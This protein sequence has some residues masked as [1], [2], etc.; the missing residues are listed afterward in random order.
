[1]TEQL[2]RKP[3]HDVLGMHFRAWKKNKYTIFANGISAAAIQIPP[4]F[5]DTEYLPRLQ[6][7]LKG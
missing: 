2:A 4:N 3:L 5:C 7:P 6:K 1:M